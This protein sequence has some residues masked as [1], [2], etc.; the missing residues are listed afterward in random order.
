MSEL[1]LDAYYDLTQI[2][3]VAVS[4]TGD[5]VAFAATE[6]DQAA[7]EAVSSLF[8]APTDGS[9]EPHRLT[10]AS[11]A[12]APTWGPDGD[13]LAFVAARDRDAERRVGWRDRDEEDDGE[14]AET[15]DE[16]GDEAE[17]DEDEPLGNGDE[18]PKPQVWIFDLALGGDARQVTERD[19]GVAGFDWSPEGDRLVIES[20]DPTDEESEYLD[21]VREEG[22]PIETTR[23][24]HKVNGAGWTDEVTRYLFVVDLDDPESDPRRLDDA[25]GGGA[26]EDI[27]GMDPTWGDGGRI[28]FTSCRLDRPDDTTVRDLYAVSPDGGDAERLTGGDLSHGAPAWRP[29]GDGIATVASDPDDPPAPAEVYLIGADPD[30]PVSLTADLDRTVARGGGIEW[31][32]GAIYTRIADESRTRLVRVET[33]GTVERI[34]EAQGRDRAMAGFDVADDGSTAVTVLSEP[35]S[36]TDLYAVDVDDLDEESEPD[37][38]RRLTRVNESLVDEFSMPEARRVEWESDGWTL[39]GVLYHDPEMDPEAGDHPLVVA[40]HGGPMSYDEPVFS[41]GHAA[42]TS[43]GYLVFRP[44]YRGGTSRGREFTAELTGEWGT[45]EVDDIAAGVESLADR[46][47]VDPDRVFG[48]GFSYGGIAQGFLVTQEPE[49][50]TAAAPEHGIYD[51]RSAFGTDDTHIWMEAEFGLPWE[52]PEAFDASSAIL[53]AGDIE[54]PLL[55]MAGGED[56]R[57]PPSQSEQLYVAA[58]KQ[59]VD[60]ELVVYPD[61]HHNIGDP[62]RAI[63]RLEKI[64]GWYETHDPAVE[65]ADGE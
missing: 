55:V 25:Y 32:D 30:D 53:D 13:R 44:N 60:A 23:L 19:E 58:R 20:R 36:G 59:G 61:E 31:V 57:C 64:L 52:N 29:G 33:D 26:F 3:E 16:E 63:H 12:S 22:G 28:A 48:H 35:E 65:D 4:P 45:A 11:G 49:L 41:F 6:Y 18:E 43:R 54:T 24:Q 8:V 50:F 62:D 17:E 46:G 27:A 40:I 21:Q 38:F 9:R 5:R 34:F 51:I 2:G 14:G 37:S 10:S 47:W 42:L 1:P 7:D 15:E 56:W 39:D